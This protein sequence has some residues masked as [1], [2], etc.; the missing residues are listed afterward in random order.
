MPS[1]HTRVSQPYNTGKGIVEHFTLSYFAE[2][3]ILNGNT[4]YFYV[5]T[6]KLA[7]QLPRSKSNRTAVVD[8]FKTRYVPFVDPS[9]GTSCV[10]NAVYRF[11]INVNCSYISICYFLQ[12]HRSSK[13]LTERFS[14][15][16][17]LIFFMQ[18]Y[19]LNW[20][21]LCCNFD[22]WQRY[23]GHMMLKINVNSDAGNRVVPKAV[24]VLA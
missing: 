23:R 5:S 1:F 13:L 2:I 17:V 3:L 7:F 21:Q 6:A 24:S 11:V 16:R 20:R 18:L 4:S 12:R 19:E 9:V 14:L 22:K 10:K 8:W 15:N